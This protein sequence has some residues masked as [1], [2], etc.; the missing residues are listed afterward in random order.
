MIGVTIS[1]LGGSRQTICSSKNVNYNFLVKQIVAILNLYFQKTL[2]TVEGSKIKI[3]N[4][5]NKFIQHQHGFEKRFTIIK[6]KITMFEYDP[7]ATIW[8]RISQRPK[9]IRTIESTHEQHM[10]LHPESA[11]K[12]EDTE[13]EAN[14]QA[15]TT[16]S[17]EIFRYRRRAIWLQLQDPLGRGWGEPWIPRQIKRKGFWWLQTRLIFKPSRYQ[18]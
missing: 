15:S 17:A 14:T 11:P 4:Q 8:E 9:Y 13:V 1:Q 3:K 6:A 12:I 2:K 16:T 10:I 7:K 5:A 18:Q